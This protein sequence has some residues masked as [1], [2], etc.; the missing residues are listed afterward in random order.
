MANKVIACGRSVMTEEKT[1]PGYERVEVDNLI[2]NYKIKWNDLIE[3]FEEVTAERDSWKNRA[4]KG[5]TTAVN[6]S[7]DRN[8]LKKELV[9]LKKKIEKLNEIK[10]NHEELKTLNKVLNDDPKKIK[11]NV[12]EIYKKKYKEIDEEYS[13]KMDNL[14]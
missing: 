10:Y 12:D 3:Q 8:K 1:D 5:D 4:D 2:N 11:R 13:K 7:N 14:M 9:D 6:L